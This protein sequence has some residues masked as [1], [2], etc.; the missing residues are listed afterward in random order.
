MSGP[1]FK[2]N[3]RRTFQLNFAPR[4]VGAIFKFIRDRVDAGGSS[5]TKLP[6]DQVRCSV[7]LFSEHLTKIY[8]LD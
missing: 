5:M 2:E 6:Y 8:F 3:V 7:F 4:E 1:V